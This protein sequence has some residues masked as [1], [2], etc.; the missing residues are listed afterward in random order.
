MSDLDNV[1]DRKNGKH[2]WTL[3]G[4][5]GLITAIVAALTFLVQTGVLPIDATPA[6]LPAPT[7][8]IVLAVSTLLPPAAPPPTAPPVVPTPVLATSIPPARPTQAVGIT[9]EMEQFVTDF[10]ARAIAAEILAFTYS[11]ATYAAQFT[12]GQRLLD[13]QESLAALVSEGLYV[14]PQF[15]SGQSYIADIRIVH[16]N[17]LEVDTCEV[18]A[19]TFYHLVDGVVVYVE[20]PTL[21]PQTI[22]I[23][24]FV[25]GWFITKIAFYNPPSF[26]E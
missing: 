10:L 9:S 3:G 17:M 14:V 4:L 13:V 15:D 24:R 18:W 6:G 7:Q 11:D 12:T 16:D 20:P 25:E 26:C 2:F 5:A 1:Y 21:M 22:T 19:K 23:E 8:I